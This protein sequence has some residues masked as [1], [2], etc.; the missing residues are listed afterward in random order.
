MSLLTPLEIGMGGYMRRFYAQLVADTPS[1][2]EYVTRGLSKAMVW[3]PGRMIDQIED[4]LKEYR[5]NENDAGPG[6]SSRLPIAFV[7]MAKDFMPAPP[8]WGIAVGSRVW[9]TNPDDPEQRAFKVR[10]SFNEYR[11]QVV[12]AAAEK[13]T[14]H[15]LAMQFNLFANGDDDGGGRRFT[16]DV[17]FAGMTHQF[18][19]ALEQIDLGAVSMPVEVKDLTIC[20]VDLNVRAHVPLFEAPK[21]GEP[22][23]G[24]PAPS[25]Y[26]VVTEVTSEQ[27]FAETAA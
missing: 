18:Q 2:Q 4:M 24:K 12:I 3:V 27:V 6:L 10:T 22:N 20:T 21:D 14:A 25:G 26:Q 19:A 16:F 7:A 15:S 8:E 1:M 5:K 9:V 11:A 13:H 23:D 17:P